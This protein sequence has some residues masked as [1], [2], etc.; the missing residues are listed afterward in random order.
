MLIILFKSCGWISLG[1]KFHNMGGTLPPP[2]KSPPPWAPM[3]MAGRVLYDYIKAR[4]NSNP[5][6]DHRG[7]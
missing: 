3:V 7:L 5:D 6:L 1:R 4:D 2:K